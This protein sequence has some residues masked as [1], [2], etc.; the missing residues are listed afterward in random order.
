SEQALA[1][2]YTCNNAI[3]ITAGTYNVDTITG[4][5]PN[6]VCV[7]TGDATHAI[8]YSYTPTADHALTITTDLPQNVGDDTRFHV[9]TGN[10]GD[11]ILQCEA[12][13]D[14]SGAGNTSIATFNVDQG[15]TYLIVFDDRWMNTSFD[16]QLIEN[17]P[18]PVPIS[19]SPGPT[20]GTY[21]MGA[22]DMNGDHL[23]DVVSP[24]NGS[25]LINEQQT[26][27][28]L[29][30]VSRP[31]P[32]TQHDPSWSFCVGDIDKNGYNDMMY[33]SNEGASF[34][35][36]N[37]TGTAFTEVNFPNYIFCQRT[38]MVD[39]NNDGHLDAFSCHDVDANVYFSNDGTGALTFHQG[40]LGPTCGNYGSIWVDYDNDGDQ[41]LFIAKCGCD[42]VDLFLRNDGNMV[43]PS[44][45]GEY[46]FQ[47]QH[48]SWSSAWGDFDND[49]D[50]DVLVG[51]SS[52]GYH[53]LMRNDSP[54]FTNV[55]PGSGLDSFSGQ[56][57]E[58]VTHDFNND[59]Y[60][61][62]LGGYGFL[63]GHGDMTFTAVEDQPTNGPIGDLNNDGFLDIVSNGRVNLNDGNENHWLTVNTV[64]TVSNVN[65]IGA[66]VIITSALGTQIRD[67]RS[68][69]GFE[70]MSTL[71]SHFGLG[72]DSVVS[73]LTIE[74]PSG[75]TSTLYDVT[76]DQVIT[77][78]E[79]VS[80]AVPQTAANELGLY[81]VPAENVLYVR[82]LEKQGLRTAQ[83][84]N[85][86]GQVVLRTTVRAGV[87]DVSTLVP[88]MYVLRV[89]G[90][91]PQQA[92]F[93]KQ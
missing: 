47:D 14:E 19:F 63:L 37:P 41:D 31:V 7:Q 35:M 5:T 48:Q 51:A 30:P 84:L 72:A 90:D 83:V 8:W 44:V 46:G 17:D 77:V 62:I 10:C 21:P 42:P 60:L 81:P 25:V 65:A 32:V 12:G 50:M 36:A 28:T 57:I 64:G 59:G 67:V 45:A 27:G 74:W 18:L 71:N 68:G 52:S 85:A 66:R 53:K 26:D 87:L 91:M 79:G 22:V 43:F 54:G 20:I 29:V 24:A 38:N 69:D 92:P 4:V 75:L 76:G 9:F 3:P 15:V 39:I 13:D 11:F 80:T 40:G 61:D 88:G 33:G 89:D 2:G 93:V 6:D 56:S 1:P 70:Y 58:W 82:G 73:N 55:T 23:D 16:F 49:G 34:M 78:V 86:A